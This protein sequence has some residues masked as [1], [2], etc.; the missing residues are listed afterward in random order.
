MDPKQ[1]DACNTCPKKKKRGGGSEAGIN[2]VVI[3][4]IGTNQNAPSSKCKCT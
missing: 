4:D 3:Q 1:C 2:L